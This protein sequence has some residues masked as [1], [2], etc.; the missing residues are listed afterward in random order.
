[1][2]LS[3]KPDLD[4]VKEM[5]RHFWNQELMGR[6]PVV[7]SLPRPGQEGGDPFSL[8]YFRAMTG[9]WDE[10]L[11]LIDAHLEATEHLAESIP[12]YAPDHGPDQFTAFLGGT[13]EFS[14]SSPD[15]N[16][17][18]PW[19]S[20]WDKALP[21]AL[22]ETNPVWQ[23]ALELSRRMAEHGRGRYLVGVCDLHS[24]MDALLAMRGGERLSM[25]FYDA[26]EQIERA[27]TEVRALYAPIY[28]RLYAAGGMGA[29]TGSLGWA[30]FWCDGRFATIQCDYICLI[31]PE[32]SRR[33]VIPALEEEAAF[34]DHCVYHFDG[35]GALPHL[36]DILAVKGIDCI[37]WV[38]GAGRA[39]MHEW[40]DVLQRCQKAGKSL[41][42]YGVNAEQV[43]AL[44][45]QLEPN[46][47][48][49][50]VWGGSR[51]EHNDLLT[52]LTKHS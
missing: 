8:R 25:D 17:I 3:T 26:P 52:W 30:P 5:W 45:P 27:M 48:A 33:F 7:A 39:A 23:S 13:L 42:V 19:V 29:D 40:T 51:E 49:Y 47:V 32:M 28:D 1:M 31:S 36:D 38:P 21:L 50:C 14:E 41:Q 9:R 22:Q 4:R 20:D 24:N 6:P 16:W 43:K 12:H 46:K 15:T 11:A 37:Q 2:Q 35:V 10:L 44:H 34:L 18:E